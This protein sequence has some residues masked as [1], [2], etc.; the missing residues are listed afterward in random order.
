MKFTIKN[1]EYAIQKIYS[2]TYSNDMKL[3]RKG[4]TNIHE[5]IERIKE[6]KK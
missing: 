3:I 5:I 1:I 2:D 6:E 4:L